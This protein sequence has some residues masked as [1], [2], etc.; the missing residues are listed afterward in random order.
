MP[1]A[2]KYLAGKSVHVKLSIADKPIS[3]TVSSVEEA[4]VWLT[5]TPLLEIIIQSGV[6]TTERNLVVFVP[7]QQVEWI[8][9]PPV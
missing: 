3:C 6:K 8:L 1:N 9:A 7:M 4:G 5:G 2:L